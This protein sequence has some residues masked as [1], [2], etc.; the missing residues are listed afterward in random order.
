MFF[1]F[2]WWGYE[3]PIR[4]LWETSN[5]SLGSL[6]LRSIHLSIKFLCDCFPCCDVGWPSLTIFSLCFPLS[7]FHYF[8]SFYLIWFL[9]FL[10]LFDVRLRFSIHTLLFLIL[11]IFDMFIL[12]ILTICLGIPRSGTHEVFCALHLMHGGYGDCIIGIIEPSVL[13]FLYLITLAYITS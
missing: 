6:D 5:L 9:Y 12:F 13:S 3:L 2:F 4:F 7:L 1:F 8:I 10:I 11:L